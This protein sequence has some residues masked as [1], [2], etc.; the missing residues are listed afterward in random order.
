[1]VNIEE[2]KTMLKGKWQA[3][4]GIMYIHNGDNYLLVILVRKRT[5]L[6]VQ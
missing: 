3:I 2:N 1:M 6:K 4:M 5:H